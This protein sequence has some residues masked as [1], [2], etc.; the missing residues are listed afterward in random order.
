MTVGSLGHVCIL[1]GGPEYKISVKG[2]VYIFECSKHGGPAA[3]G[4]RGQLLEN[5]PIQFLRAA[6]AWIQQGRLVDDDGLCIW[7]HEAEPI[8]QYIGPRVARVIDMG[9]PKR[10]S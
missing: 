1:T 5:Q 6:S 4:K 7:F 2:K 8:L 3:F 9:N 10:G